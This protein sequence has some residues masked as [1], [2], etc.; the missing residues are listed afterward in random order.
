MRARP[1]ILARATPPSRALWPHGVSGDIPILLIRISEESHIPLVRQLIK[2]REYW[3][4]KCI[5]CDFVILN[6]HSS[7][8]VQELQRSLQEIVAVNEHGPADPLGHVVLVRADLTDVESVMALRA[9]ARVDLAASR[10]L[11]EAQLDIIKGEEINPLKSTNFPSRLLSQNSYTTNSDLPT[12]LKNFNGYGGFSADG[13]EYVIV[14]K[15][16]RTTPAPWINVVANPS[17]GF[18]IS[19]EGAGFCWHGNSQQNQLTPW[20]NDPVTNES[21][22]FLYIKDLEVGDLWS[23]PLLRSRR[24]IAATFARM[25]RDIAV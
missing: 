13:R 23:P 17:F 11:L 1:D 20:S 24:P 5:A 6:E 22:D 9:A 14:A 12:G 10:G 18:Q 25:V 21:G 2:A 8:Y 19:S 7:S 16:G 15:D 3:R 4:A